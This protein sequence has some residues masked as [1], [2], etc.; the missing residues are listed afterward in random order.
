MRL[1]SLTK[2]KTTECQN[3]PGSPTNE[4]ST[5]PPIS[6]SR[7]NSRAVAA[8][9]RRSSRPPPETMAISAYVVPSPPTSSHA[10]DA[11]MTDFFGNVYTWTTPPKVSLSSLSSIASIPS[12]IVSE[13]DCQDTQKIPPPLTPY[14][15]IKA[16]SV[17]LSLQ[18]LA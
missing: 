17:Q 15:H 9:P 3:S 12:T 18:K 13:I 5:P 11:P 8:P 4:P 6:R 7:R 2:A 14:I 1:F 16:A 10:P